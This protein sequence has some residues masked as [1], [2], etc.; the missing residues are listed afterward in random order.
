MREPQFPNSV[1]IQVENSMGREAK[2]SGKVNR[3]YDFAR[4]PA[5]L[6]QA[7]DLDRRILRG[8][9]CRRERF[10]D[11]SCRGLQLQGNRAAVRC[12]ARHA[13][14]GESENSEPLGHFPPARWVVNSIDIRQD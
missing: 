8:G 4:L 6:E 11:F 2:E 10:A 3:V 7:S 12:R 13:W 9:G 14:L 5:Q 1:V